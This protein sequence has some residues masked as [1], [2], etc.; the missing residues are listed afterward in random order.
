MR[1]DYII[2]AISIIYLLGFLSVS[3]AHDPEHPELN[4]W[5]MS[6]KSKGGM[7]C[8]DGSDSKSVAADDWKSD[9]GHY[10]VLI[11]GVWMPVPDNAVVESPN[12]AGRALIWQRES[13]FGGMVILCFMPGSMT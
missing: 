10:T 13:Q 1:K 7:P 3:Y 12:L 11:G 5:Y 4:G 9:N 8:C 6:L 2:L